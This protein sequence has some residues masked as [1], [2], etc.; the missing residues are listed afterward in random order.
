[1]SLKSAFFY[2]FSL[3]FIAFIPQHI[4]A[5]KNTNPIGS[6]LIDQACQHT[7]HKE[8]CKR[9]FEL[10]PSAHDADI[11]ALALMSLRIAST[12]A[13]NISEGAKMLLSDNNLDPEVQD[14]IADC[15]EHYLDAS[16][17]LDDS[18]AALLSNAIKDVETWV[19]VAI[20]D[21]KSCDS[22]LKGKKTDMARKNKVF[23]Q[24]CQNALAL[25][26]IYVTQHH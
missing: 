1:M 23:K 20:D 14:G 3:C 16:E 11:S 17:Q 2:L 21:A 4:L 5:N 24:L 6:N 18:I 7:P 22:V 8:V 15:L 10:D 13:S 25:A 26:H 9:V 19:N 12:N